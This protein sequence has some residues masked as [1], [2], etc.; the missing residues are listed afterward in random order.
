MFSSQEYLEKQ[1]RL[2]RQFSEIWL[3]N[4]TVEEVF[5]KQY[6]LAI[7]ENI[8]SYILEELELN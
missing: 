6:T 8:K 7:L 1:D 4:L 5:K 3:A 2:E